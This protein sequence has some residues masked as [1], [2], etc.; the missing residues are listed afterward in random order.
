MEAPAAAA[1]CASLAMVLKFSEGSAPEVS[2][3]TA[4]RPRAGGGLVCEACSLIAAGL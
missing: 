3:A 2:C 1:S 4:T